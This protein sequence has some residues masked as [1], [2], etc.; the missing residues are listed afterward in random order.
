MN[1][2][3][4]NSAAGKQLRS[5]IERIEYVNGEI[6][7]RNSDRTEIFL[8]AKALGFCGKTMREILRLRRMS[9]SERQEAEALLEVY[10]GAL[11]MLDGTPL[12]EFAR[13]KLSEQPKI[14]PETGEVGENH[15]TPPD[16]PIGEVEQ[17]PE[18]QETVEESREKGRQAA[19]DGLK[20]TEN[21]YPAGDAKRAAWDEGWCEEQGSDGMGIPTAW[22]RKDSKP[23]NSKPDDP[24]NGNGANGGAA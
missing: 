6:A 18:I 14:N 4:H 21:P 19:R 3:G 16:L 23:D 9:E 5:F 10:K 13:K 22:R 2:I 15:D 17:S 8:E 20:V 12:G 11:G 7:K 24:K 1:G